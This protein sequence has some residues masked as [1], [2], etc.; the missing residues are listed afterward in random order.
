MA[1]DQH[2]RADRVVVLSDNEELVTRFRAMLDDDFAHLR[3][4][5][6]FACSPFSSFL[7]QVDVKREWQSLVGRYGLVIS[8]HCKQI[9]PADMVRAI[10][11]VNV[12]P[13]FNPW[14]RGWYPQVF[15][16]INKLPMGATI[17]EIDE[18]LDHGPIIDQASI[19]IAS[20][21]TSLDVYRRALDAEIVL[22]RRSLQSIVDGTYRAIAPQEEG[23]VN[24]RRDFDALREIDR[25]EVGTFGSFVDRLRA[26][27]HGEFRNAFF[28]DDEGRKVF[29][30]CTLER[31]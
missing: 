31:E 2:S 19:P 10:R 23:N 5:F 29:I 4:R 9:F 24:L 18:E 26:L 8:L 28:V 16:I 27:T 22:L 30:R 1:P 13:G 15:S 25:D 17:H 21:E 7:P 6:D 20:H 11:C 14:N 3:D 12:H